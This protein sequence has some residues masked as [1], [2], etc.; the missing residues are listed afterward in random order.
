MT[1]INYEI[2]RLLQYGIQKK[3]LDKMDLVYTRNSIL[4][5]LE[6][7][8][9]KGVEM[10]NETLENPV[11]ILENILDWAAENNRL[12]ENTVTYRDLLDT[13]LMG[14][15]MPRPSEVVKEFYKNLEKNGVEYATENYYAMS[16]AS[17]YIRTERTA[18]NMHW[19]SP[20]EYGD[21]EITV[22][23]S[24]PEKD[25][26]VIAA[27]K[28]MKSSS[29]PKCVLCKENEGYRGR[30]NHPARQNHRIIPLDLTGEEWFLQYSPYVYYNEHSIIF[31]EEHRPMKISK[32]SFMRLLEFVEKFP[33]YF[34]GSNA[35]LPIVGG[36]ILS[37]DHF[38]G[39]NH[40]FAMAKAPVE[41]KVKFKKYPNIEG[42]IVKWPMSVIRLSSEN[43]SELAELADEILHTWR[44]YSDE[45][46][47]IFADTGDEPHNTVTPI[48]RKRGEIFE[49]DIV[50]RN[51]RTSDEHPLGIF[52][53]HREVH[54]I[55]KENIGL[56]EVMGLAV[57]PGRLK[58]EL[59]I[60]EEVLLKDNYI[61]EIEKNKKIKKHLSWAKKIKEKY[62]NLTLDSVKKVLHEE[63]GLVFSKVLED[64]GVYKR[65]GEGQGAFM[66]FIKIFC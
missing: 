17:N 10:K 58:E 45:E 14:C 19:Y 46:I 39:G 25:P 16:K 65:D 36:S 44:N 20:T 30:L 11:E 21:L 2:E 51:N 33:H 57:L 43:S 34:I 48:V 53:P 42:G 29:Y 35:D 49:L 38:Q 59:A 15:L 4:E 47:G 26:K 55:K 3:L 5:V 7:D 22:N 37:H 64:A 23:L 32:V 28:H 9:F 61:E 12:A 52:H 62:N 41:K 6:I 13:R 63:V 27:A 60:L 31:S 54:N 1:D 8:E 50:L 56:I 18:K 40:E 24:K 66:K